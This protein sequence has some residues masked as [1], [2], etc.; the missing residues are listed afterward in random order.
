M[1]KK[2]ISTQSNRILTYFNKLDQDCFAYAEA[3]NALP[4]S[5][6]SALKELL[7]NMVKR[8]LLMRLKKGL[9]FIIPYE[10]RLNLLCLIGISLQV[11]LQK[12]AITIL[13]ITQ[14]CKYII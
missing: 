3:I 13:A 4:N 8:G 2:Y 11:T 5:S 10:K 1:Y 6:N 12:V 9:Y 14:H 7:S